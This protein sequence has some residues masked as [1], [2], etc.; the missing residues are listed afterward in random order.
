MAKIQGLKKGSKSRNGYA[1]G[2][3][4]G[5]SKK[6]SI[7]RKNPAPLTLNHEDEENV[8]KAR[9]GEKTKKD[10]RNYL[11]RK[12]VRKRV[13]FVFVTAQTD[14]RKRDRKRKKPKRRG[15]KKMEQK[16][17]PAHK[18]LR[19]QKRI[20]AQEHRRRRATADYGLETTFP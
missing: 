9:E 12:K 17:N 18:K 1:S 8:R 10:F 20:R 4:R 15:G 16:K 19:G 2:E 11:N 5:R 3:T 7:S 13:F 14:G 6:R